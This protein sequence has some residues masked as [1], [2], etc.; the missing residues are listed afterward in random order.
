MVAII[1]SP[2]D[3]RRWSFCHAVTV[4]K[5]SS[6]LMD[7]QLGIGAR[8]CVQPM[9]PKIT[10]KEITPIREVLARRANTALARAV[11]PIPIRATK[12]RTRLPVRKII[13]PAR[14]PQHTSQPAG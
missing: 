8:I 3:Y 12:G 10:V 2:D 14:Q 7:S 4:V 5:V 9:P 13:P 11:K 6:Y 1:G